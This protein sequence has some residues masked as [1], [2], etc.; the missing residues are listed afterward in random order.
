MRM[1][2]GLGRPT[3]GSVL[4]NGRLLA[5]HPAPLNVVGALLEARAMHP[6][7][8]ARNHLRVLAATSGI[9]R[10]RVEQV[11]DLV[12]LAD[13][14][15]QRVSDFGEAQVNL[16]AGLPSPYAYLWSLPIKTRDPH[17]A[18]LYAV[19]AGPAAP[20][21]SQR[22]T[23]S[24]STCSTDC[25]ERPPDP[26]RQHRGA[27]VALV[28]PRC[29]IVGDPEG[30]AA[31][32]REIVRL[33]RMRDRRP[34][35]GVARSLGEI[36]QVGHLLAHLVGGVVGRAPSHRRF[37]PRCCGLQPGGPRRLIRAPRYSTRSGS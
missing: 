15:D 4:V 37:A 9:G 29:G 17:L 23:A 25:T 27:D 3:S 5:D 7:R 35:C 12:G 36:G 28:L 2:L 21:W 8:T 18:D 19:L 20:T 30:R 14:A 16:A 11:I 26:D 13:A 1:M 32:D 34:V 22:S 10:A 24:R 6:G 31:G 33:T